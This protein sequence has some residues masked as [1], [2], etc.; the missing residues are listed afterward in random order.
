[1]FSPE[2]QAR[3]EAAGLLWND[4]LAAWA[5]IEAGFAPT[6]EPWVK[7]TTARMWIRDVIQR[8][9]IEAATRANAPAPKMKTYVRDPNPLFDA[10]TG[11][12]ADLTKKSGCGSNAEAPRGSNSTQRPGEITAPVLPTPSKAFAPQ[13][14]KLSATAERAMRDFGHEVKDWHGDLA[15]EFKANPDLMQSDRLFRCIGGLAAMGVSN[16][17]PMALTFGMAAVEA[18]LGSVRAMVAKGDRPIHRPAGLV[19]S[20]IRNHKAYTVLKRGAA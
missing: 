5:K 14:S 4:V 8:G 19:C 13:E 6:M 3:A 17:V 12:M 7:E 2:T 15:D 20:F 1:M 16:P 9:N 11:E 10:V 18:S